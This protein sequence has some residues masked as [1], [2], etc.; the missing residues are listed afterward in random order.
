MLLEFRFQNFRSFRDEQNFSMLADDH[1][2]EQL[3][4]T[5]YD[6]SSKLLI[7]KSS[8]IYGSNA[9]GKSNFMKAIQAFRMMILTSANNSP[10]D[11]FEKYE[12][13][14]FSFEFNKA[15]VQFEADFLIEEIKYTYSFSFSESRVEQEN[16]YYYPQKRKALLFSRNHQDFVFGDHLKGHK[17]VVAELT[18]EN[19][20]FLS[21]GA[22][23]NIP[24]LKSLYSFVNHDFMAI[25]FLDSWV[26]NYYSDKI[27]KELLNDNND[28]FI[29]NFKILLQSFDTGIIDFSV[30]E[31]ELPW[32]K[33]EIF[34]VHDN[35]DENDN[36]IGF[37]AMPLAEEST[38]TQK[39]FVLGGLVLRALMN[40]RTIL[41][42][43]FER[44]LHPIIS[45]YIIQL[46]NNPE[47]NTKNAQLILATH[48]T[49]LLGKEN[50]LRRDQIWIVE[51]DEKGRSEL[52]SVSDIEG[53]RKD[54]P[55]EK[56]YLSGR[57]GG[58][59][60]IESLNFKLNFQNNFSK[61]ND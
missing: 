21:K 7:L 22:Q 24:Q 4:N 19:Q 58:I 37:S 49:N 45:Q 61:I 34:A 13:F 10:G 6:D 44:S 12:P 2:D 55:F 17:S 9:S 46:F 28:V 52:F 48:D 3:Q 25:P 15:P 38:G 47:V 20:L 33:Y 30:K 39:L 23:N 51:K 35:F 56:W 14:T 36:N 18:T 59:P 8:I 26:D 50:N 60:G 31:S 40:G 11:F 1:K 16:L 57:F 43:E 41:F 32:E 29:Q 27:A 54:T 5:F 42:D 53:I